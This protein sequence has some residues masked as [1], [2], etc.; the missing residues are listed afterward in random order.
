MIVTLATQV[1]LI[2]RQQLCRTKVR[3]VDCNDGVWNVPSE[4][5]LHTQI[6]SCGCKMDFRM[7]TSQC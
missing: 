4:F 6:E 2:G 1:L 5:Q 3:L 7:P